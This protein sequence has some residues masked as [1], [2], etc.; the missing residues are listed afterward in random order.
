MVAKIAF[1]R[2]AVYSARAFLEPHLSLKGLGKRS[3]NFAEASEKKRD[4]FENQV[5]RLY[6]S[7]LYS[8][9]FVLVATQLWQW[10]F[11][12]LY[13][14]KQR[15]SQN[16]RRRDQKLYSQVGQASL[17]HLNYCPAAQDFGVV[18]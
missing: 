11:V 6:E 4:F 10:L 3:S 17:V 12:C 14:A 15:S 2:W 5:R 1:A 16:E 9:A 18:H 8:S 13:R 7:I